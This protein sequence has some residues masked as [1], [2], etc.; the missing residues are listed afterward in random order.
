MK[1]ATHPSFP[2][3]S[4]LAHWLLAAMAVLV[5]MVAVAEILW[6]PAKLAA[7]IAP[8]HAAAHALPPAAR[9]GVDAADTSVPDA[10]AVFNGRETTPEQ[11][12]PTF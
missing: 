6:T 8:A 10:A 3:T 2:E 4:R 11:P 7:S 12:T 5:L 1:T 9:A